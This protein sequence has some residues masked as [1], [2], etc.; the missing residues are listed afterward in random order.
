[1]YS[2]IPTIWG[3]RFGYPRII[4]ISLCV[5][6]LTITVPVSSPK[7]MPLNMVCIWVQTL[8]PYER[9]RGVNVDMGPNSGPIST[10]GQENSAVS[11]NESPV[12]EVCNFSADHQRFF[13]P[14][15]V[16]EPMVSR[17]VRDPQEMTRSFGSDGAFG[18]SGN[19]SGMLLNVWDIFFIGRIISNLAAF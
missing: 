19:S 2:C 7:E 16:S 9:K 12:P 8:D 15:T 5:N 13:D 4:R 3:V 6:Y 18:V 17:V 10:P 14:A 1:M 11:E